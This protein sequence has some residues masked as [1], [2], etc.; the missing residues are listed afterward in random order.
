MCALLLSR[1]VV[2]PCFVQVSRPKQ[3]AHYL[4][5]FVP[6][7]VS[8]P[9][10]TVCL[11]FALQTDDKRDEM[12]HKVC[13]NKNLDFYAPFNVKASKPETV[14]LSA[15]CSHPYSQT[16]YT[17]APAV[18]FFVGGPSIRPEQQLI[19]SIIASSLRANGGATQAS[20]PDLRIASRR[21]GEVM[22]NGCYIAIQ[23]V[24]HKSGEWLPVDDSNVIQI[25]FFD[26]T[27]HY[28]ASE[29]CGQSELDTPLYTALQE[30]QVN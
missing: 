10:C 26:Y 29:A 3:G 9:D 11:R 12:V 16:N 28:H 6:V 7:E 1:V 2:S 15:T 20:A 19:A 13:N 4:N 14:V 5:A 17:C 8:A 23:A 21:P 24:R 22:V 27:R 18:V 25:S 30:L